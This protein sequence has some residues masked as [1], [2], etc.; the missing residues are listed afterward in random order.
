MGLL[1]CFA[2]ELG[3]ESVVDL[4][5]QWAAALGPQPAAGDLDRR[6]KV[7]VSRR[8]VALEA[9]LIEDSGDQV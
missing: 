1:R 6:D 3:A 5:E 9:F 7:D 4:V 8:G 2:A